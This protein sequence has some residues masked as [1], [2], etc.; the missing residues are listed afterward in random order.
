MGKKARLG[1][2]FETTEIRR[3]IISAAARQGMSPTA[4]C[5]RAIEERLVRDGEMGDVAERKTFLAEMAR[6]RE[7]RG[8]IDVS[9]IGSIAQKD[10]Q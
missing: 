10:K 5:T 6:F 4:Y 9:A 8:I 1:L 7:E 3:L 2:Y